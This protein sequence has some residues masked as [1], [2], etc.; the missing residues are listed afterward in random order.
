V[1][2]L[3]P[4]IVTEEEIEEAVSLIERVCAK[5]TRIPARREAA[6]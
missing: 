6:R 4:L 2:L 5:L 1:R 3:P